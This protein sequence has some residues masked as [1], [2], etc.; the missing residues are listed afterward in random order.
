MNYLK[1]FHDRMLE[2][3][4]ELNNNILQEIMIEYEKEFR[5]TFNALVKISDLSIFKTKFL[6]KDFEILEI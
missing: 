6:S 5:Q 4:G 3:N 2:I 1:L